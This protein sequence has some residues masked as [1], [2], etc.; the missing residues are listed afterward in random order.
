MSEFSVENLSEK[1]HNGKTK[2]YFQEVLS[3][4][5]NGNYRSAVVM[6]W[7]VAVCDIIYKLQF[8]VD[9]YDDK[10]AKSILKEIT[11]IQSRDPKSSSWETKLLEDTHEKTKLLDS[12]EYQNLIYV[13]KQRH[14]S[15]HPTLNSDRELH[16]PNKETVRAL[17]RNTLEGVLIKPPFY[18]QK[19][20]DEILTDI[21]E[22]APMINTRE[23]AKSYIESRY[24]NRLKPETEI[25]I[26]RNMWKLVFRLD[27]EKCNNNRDINLQ[28]I[29]II[30][31]R[32]FDRIKETISGDRD[33]YSHISTQETILNY[34]VFYL[35]KNFSIYDFLSDDA[36]LKIQHNIQTTNVGRI[37]G[38]F[39]WGNLEQYY[40]NILLL[41]NNNQTAKFNFKDIQLQFIL[42]VSDTNE[43]KKMF[44]NIVSTYYSKSK[45][46]NQADFRFEQAI[47]PHLQMFDAETIKFLIECI[48]TND[49]VYSRS[50]AAKDHNQIHL[51]L[52]EIY[53]DKFD[54]T[55]YK[56]FKTNLEDYEKY[57]KD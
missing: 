39:I 5:Q 55:P 22:T 56:K 57:W 17:I 14:L 6:L 2:L 38:W 10:Q 15:A 1:I 53:G 21:A 31:K 48:E 46:Y 29:D 26:Y 52:G 4:Y 13:Q 42:E 27:D 33:Y 11:E 50:Q 12:A 45:I 32:N 3:S 47:L 49:Q 37:Y 30:G 18:T 36:K 8:L 25:S 40:E 34:L 24:L 23:K 28:V 9:L 43:W 54:S 7:S 19:I 44:C 20:I 16:T 41:I 35:G 51:R